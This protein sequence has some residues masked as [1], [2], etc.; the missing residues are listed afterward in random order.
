MMKEDWHGQTLRLEKRPRMGRVGHE[1]PVHLPCQVQGAQ[2]VERQTAQDA[3]ETD[4]RDL[5]KGA[6]R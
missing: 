2:G 5:W 6:I 1:L 4:R 3:T